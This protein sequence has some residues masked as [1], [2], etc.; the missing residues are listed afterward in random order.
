MSLYGIINSARSLSYYNKLQAA[1]ANNLANASSAGYKADRVTARVLTGGTHPVPVDSL[2]LSQGNI[3]DT[4]RTLDVALQGEGFLVVKTPNGE[5]LTRGGS[6]SLD[7][8]GFLADHNGNQVLG[9]DGPMR[10]TGQKIEIQSDGTVAVDGKEVGRLRLETV[11]DPTQLHKEGAGLYLSDAP[12]QAADTASVQQGAVEDANVD[13]VMGTV[14]LIMIQ[15]AYTAN[16][17]A[18]K[19]MDGV[20]ATV[21][22]D[23]GRV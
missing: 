13:P 18:L 3:R 15:R 12:T 2:D 14:D 8:N 1:V 7:A 17:D 20:M 16:I 19:A 11:K 23:V 4:G 22:S 9:A 5:R 21:T 10:L 6:L